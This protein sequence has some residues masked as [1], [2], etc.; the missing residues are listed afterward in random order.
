MRNAVPGMVVGSAFTRWSRAGL[1]ALCNHR[2]R[3]GVPWYLGAGLTRG[4][5][6]S[7]GRQRARRSGLRSA[8]GAFG[9]STGRYDFSSSAMPLVYSLRR[10]DSDFVVFCFSK[11]EDAEAFDKR[12]GGEP[13][14]TSGRR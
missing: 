11:S 14:P 8:V 6:T 2:R 9:G 4:G 3:V 7:L 1:R 12:F 5:P 13:L 10:G